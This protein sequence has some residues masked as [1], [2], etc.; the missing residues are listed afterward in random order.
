VSGYLACLRQHGA[1]IPAARPTAA[2]TAPLSPGTDRFL[3]GLKPAAPD[4][5]AAL[6]ACQSKLP[7]FPVPAG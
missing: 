2:P 7:A 4:V 5:A 3:N 6:R 1:A